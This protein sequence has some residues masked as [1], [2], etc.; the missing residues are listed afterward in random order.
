MLLCVHGM[1]GMIFNL[2]QSLFDCNPKYDEKH[3]ENNSEITAL[4][5][6][7]PRGKSATACY[8]S[9]VLVLYAHR[10]IYNEDGIFKGEM[11]ITIH[12]F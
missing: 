10:D 6:F 1:A 2:D 3:I 7:N 8:P 4:L 11:L 12:I 9:N 5:A